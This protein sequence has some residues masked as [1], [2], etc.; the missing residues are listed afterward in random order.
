ML[1]LRPCRGS[2][3]HGRTEAAGSTSA[4]DVGCDVEGG[5]T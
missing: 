2:L 5:S 3:A 1:H 4:G